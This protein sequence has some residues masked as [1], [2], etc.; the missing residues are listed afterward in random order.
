MA[1]LV[2]L[3][4]AR[5]IPAISRSGIKTSRLGKVVYAMPVLPDFFTSHQWL[6]ELKQQGART[7]AGVY[8]RVPDTEMVYAGRYDRPHRLLPLGKAI[9]EIMA[10]PDPLGYELMLTRKVLPAELIRIKSLPQLVGWRHFPHSHNKRPCN[11]EVCLRGAIK[12]KRTRERLS[13]KLDR[14]FAAKTR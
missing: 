2:H 10:L 6:R 9:A 3:A 11:C 1:V 5:N 7:I 12:G 4:D 14:E 8:F 13:Q